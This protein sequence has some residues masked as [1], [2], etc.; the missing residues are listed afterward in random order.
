MGALPPLSRRLR[1]HRRRLAAAR[2]LLRSDTQWFK[3]HPQAL[4]RFRPERRADFELFTLQGGDP[5]AFIPNGLDPTAPLTWVAVVDVLQALGLS[6]EV[7]VG[8]LRSRI[9]TVPIR[10]QRL[11]VRM[12]EEFA[13]AV[14]RDLLNQ[15]QEQSGSQGLVA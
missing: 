9:R 4:V 13:I 10:S 1:Q 7:G 5:P 2:E 6:G 14:C 11:R 12:A 8:C 15:I 3:R